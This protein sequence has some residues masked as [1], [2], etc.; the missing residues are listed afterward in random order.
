M[1]F[2][3]GYEAS[4]GHGAVSSQPDPNA[5][6]F[7]EYMRASAQHAPKQPRTMSSAQSSR[8]LSGSSQQN[9]LV[10]DDNDGDDDIEDGSQEAPDGSQGYSEAVLSYGLYGTLASK[11]VGCRFY[12]G[13]ATMGEMALVRREP[14]NP[15]DRES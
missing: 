8:Q 6:S 10:I 15:Y 11:I 13:Y 3:R 12:N 1:S 5:S 4:N 14:H 9:P 7:E 2:K